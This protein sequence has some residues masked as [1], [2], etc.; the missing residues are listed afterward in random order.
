M[1]RSEMAGLVG[2][3]TARMFSTCGQPARSRLPR[4]EAEARAH[5]PSLRRILLFNEQVRAVPSQ[6]MNPD[7]PA[8]GVLEFSL[9]LR[10]P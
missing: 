10:Q 8:H 6:Q 4:G 1:S 7:T 3:P 5:L 2:E 9:V